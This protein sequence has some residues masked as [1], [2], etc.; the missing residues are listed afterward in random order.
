MQ[1]RRADWIERV[2]ARLAGFD[3]LVGPTVPI[4]AP[5]IAALAASDETFFKANGLLLRN[6]FAINFLD[7][8]SFSL[9]CHDEG[10]MPV[11]LMLS[12]PRGHDAALAG[13]ALA[14]EALLSPGRPGAAR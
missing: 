10:A 6:T 14:V 13:V 12:A 7:G 11:G 4:V 9:P 3:A 2:N 5:E 1:R 8:C